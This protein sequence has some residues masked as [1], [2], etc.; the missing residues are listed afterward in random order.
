MA[1]KSAW[2]AIGL[3]GRS[4]GTFQKPRDLS[5]WILGQKKLSDLT[6]F[7]GRVPSGNRGPRNNTWAPQIQESK[8]AADTP[9]LKKQFIKFTINNTGEIEREKFI[10]SSSSPILWLPFFYCDL[11]FAFLLAAAVLWSGPIYLS[12]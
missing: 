1:K 3:T 9:H 12:S 6:A 11:S 4:S 2:Q 8:S 10:R 5:L 7:Q